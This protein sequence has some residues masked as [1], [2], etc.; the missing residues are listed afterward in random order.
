MDL[1][2]WREMLNADEIG[3]E[4]YGRI[5][6]MY[7]I[8]RSITGDGFR[9]TLAMIAKDIRLDVHE[10]PTGTR[11]FDWTVPREWNIRDAYV[12]N[13]RGERVIDFARSTLHVMSYSVPV[14]A[15][16]SLAALR[17]HL[18]TL[19]DHPEWIPYRTSYY[20]EDWGFC[21]SQR[22]LE[23]LD[24]SETYDVCIDSSLTDGSLTYGEFVIPGD[25]EDEV[26]ISCH[27][28]HPS[29]CNDN[30]SGVAIA[31][32]L[33]NALSRLS[34]RYTYR[35]LF[36]PGTIGSITWLAR[37]EKHAGKIRHGLVLAC[38]GDGGGFSYKSSRQGHA[39]IDRAVR[40]VL[41][42]SGRPYTIRDFVPWGY[43]ERQYCSPGFNL[44][45]GLFSRTPHGEFPEYHTSADDLA[46]V[47]PS[48]LA[49]SFVQ[50]VKVVSVLEGDRT[51]VNQNPK[52]EPQLGRRG[53]YRAIGGAADRR[54]YE[55]ALFWVL[56]FSDGRHSLLD[57][58][59]RAGLDFDDVSS[60]AAAL[61]K[62]GLL[63]PCPEELVFQLPLATPQSS[64]EG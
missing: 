50:L 44:P 25:S 47:Q 59:E 61:R 28:C 55:L 15:R 13:A 12:K 18:H 20:K 34:L 21:L 54:G 27:A 52:C 22:Q 49:E 43:D 53:I 51:Y 4:I 17:P 30:L 41:K 37:N 7:P 24:E 3:R 46:F 57:I 31:T 10:V 42:H 16:M 26:L 56:N 35:F 23:R 32:R 11:V 5:C 40:H 39:T 63:E 9:Q 6:Q 33:A 19:P 62:N 2:D 58:A 48:W 29:L 60:A 36:I 64:R 38:V 14:K 1:R 45:V 8:C